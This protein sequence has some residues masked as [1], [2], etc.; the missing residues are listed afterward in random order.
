M[1][2]HTPFLRIEWCDPV[3]GK[4]GY[5]VVDQLVHGIAGGGLRMRPGVTMQEVEG[6]ARTMSIKKGLMKAVG[7]GAKGGIDCDPRDPRA[8]EVLRNFIKS[9]SPIFARCW[10]T[11]EDMG[12]SQRA[13]EDIFEDLGMGYPNQATLNRVPDREASLQRMASIRDLKA[14]D[15]NLATNVGG[16][17]VAEA[18]AAAAANFGW[19]MSD[20]T[21]VVQ[22]FGSMGGAAVRYL[23]R[24][25]VKVIGVADA[26]GFVRNDNGLDIETMFWARTESGEVD[27]TKLRQEDQLFSRDEWINCACDVLI[28]AALG[29]AIHEGNCD[30]IKARL[31]VEAANLATTPPARQKLHERG[32]VVI[33]DFAANSSTSA[34]FTWV[35]F[36]EVGLN[37]PDSFAKVKSVV[38]D[39]IGRILD[40]MKDGGLSPVEAGTK[41]ALENIEAMVDTYGQQY[42]VTP[43]DIAPTPVPA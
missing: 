10:S 2:K 14:D 5:A 33:P 7:G 43:G 30:A 24:M 26:E 3:T 8:P 37:G 34:W 29:G 22:G 11:G 21:C 41:V 1:T 42:P 28:P 25:G 38:H 36:G 20:L 17:G 15:A 12:V 6:L 23:V 16:Y 39:N 40:L 27:R 18:V 9:L 19:D 32:V 4:K 35:A 13:L 31:V